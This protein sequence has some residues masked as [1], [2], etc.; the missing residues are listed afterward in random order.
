MGQPVEPD[1][2]FDQQGG[3]IAL[4]QTTAD[5]VGGTIIVCLG[6]GG[7]LLKLR[8]PPSANGKSKTNVAIL[9]G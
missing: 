4:L 7:E 8:Q 5:P 9:I 1:P 2:A 6:G 3:C